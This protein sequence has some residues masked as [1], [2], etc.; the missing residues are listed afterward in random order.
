MDRTD[1]FFKIGP[2]KMS[3]A[4]I[5]TDYRTATTREEYN[6]QK[7]NI[8]RDDEYRLYLQQNA[9]NIIDNEWQLNKNLYFI[10]N[11]NCI[12]NYNTSVNPKTFY[13]ERAKYDTIYQTNKNLYPCQQFNDF[14][15]TQTKGSNCQS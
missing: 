15:L 8:V 2:A 10:C 7:K 3:D 13:V 11:K 5:F 1:N 4:R 6:K 14:R 9:E 12:H